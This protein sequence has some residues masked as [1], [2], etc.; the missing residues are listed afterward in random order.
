MKSLKIAQPQLIH[1]DPLKAT[2][3]S[4]VIYIKSFIFD[5]INFEL[6]IVHIVKGYMYLE[7]ASIVQGKL[8]RLVEKC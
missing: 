1:A 2:S 7:Y 8:K 3:H 5:N 4:K 6:V